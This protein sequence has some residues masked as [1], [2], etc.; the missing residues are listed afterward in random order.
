MI[1]MIYDIINQNKNVMNEWYN[2]NLYK[3]KK[4]FEISRST[5]KNI[6][7]NKKLEIN[8]FIEKNH[9]QIRSKK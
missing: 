1:I 7:I 9:Y 5:N 8:K 4:N 2:D 6:G 3:I